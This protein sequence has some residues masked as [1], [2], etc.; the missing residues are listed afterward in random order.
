MDTGL[1]DEVMRELLQERVGRTHLRQRLGIEHDYERRVFGQGRNFFHIENWN[2]AHSVIRNCLRLLLLHGRGRRNARRIEVRHNPVS[3]A[4]LP[5]AFENYTILQISD[6]H[7]D[8]APDFPRQL[9]E[10]VRK[11]DYDLCVLTGDFRAKTFGPYAA[12]LEGMQQVRTHLQGEVYGILGNHDSICM[13][14]GLESM[15]I[16]MLLNEQVALVRDEATIY[17]AGI[18]D[19]HYYRADNL[20]KAADD[21]PFGTVSILLAHTPE[22]YRHAAHADFNLMLCGHTHGGQICLPGGIPLMYNAHCPR[23]YCA[24]AWEYHGLQ[25]YTA[26]GSGA[27][28]VDVRLNC[29]PEITL[30]QLHC[31]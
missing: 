20:E 1:P 19:P 15:G 4:G 17:L 30:H 12:A 9:I 5:Q 24:G 7:L 6:L 31:A 23:G 29:P 21:I 28:I 22:I 10:A 8:M 11:V 3:I 27:C 13:V 18:D 16:R 2:S 26:A 14:P 25:G